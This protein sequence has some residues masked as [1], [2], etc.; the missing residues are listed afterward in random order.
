MYMCG[1]LMGLSIFM[2]D[3]S[4]ILRIVMASIAIYTLL[5][6]TTFLSRIVHD[7]VVVQKSDCLLHVM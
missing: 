6:S 4:Q 1:C 5:E 2:V 3:D 7:I